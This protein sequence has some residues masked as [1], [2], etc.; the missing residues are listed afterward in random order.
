MQGTGFTGCI[1]VRA[2]GRPARLCSCGARRGPARVQAPWRARV[3]RVR[4]CARSSP[5][6]RSGWDRRHSRPG[7]PSRAGSAPPPPDLAERLPGAPRLLPG[8]A[9]PAGL[10]Q[11]APAA[12]GGAGARPGKCWGRKGVGAAPSRPEPGTPLDVPLLAGPELQ[13]GEGGAWTGG[14]RSEVGAA[15]AVG[16]AGA[17]GSVRWRC[18]GTGRRRIPRGT[19]AGLPA[20]G[21]GGEPGGR[22]VLGSGRGRAGPCGTVRP[23]ELPGLAVLPNT[24]RGAC[25]HSHA[26]TAPPGFVH[27]LG[28][29]ALPGHPSSGWPEE[30]M[31]G[32][33][34]P[35]CG[36][37]AAA[38]SR[39]LGWE[40]RLG[41]SFC[42]SP[43]DAAAAGRFQDAQEPRA[44]PPTS[45][46]RAPGQPE[47][48]CPGCGGVSG[49][50]LQTP[51]G[52]LQLWHGKACLAHAARS[53]LGALGKAPRGELSGA[54]PRGRRGSPGSLPG[55]VGSIFPG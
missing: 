46:L 21:T 11:L 32:S 54:E 51:F 40:Q 53:V 13:P 24:S 16:G 5:G 55:C 25:T 14:G 27:R 26:L 1:A 50:F 2:K 10:R 34:S 17:V 18:R 33:C 6:F 49:G 52:P 28:G 39:V 43:S 45:L 8:R 7:S 35:V 9:A 31:Q 42:P 30:G 41:G 19:P 23:A 29:P 48:S 36:C 15:G 47:P 20:R 3:P 22:T 37:A 12:R 38:R 44:G 4:A